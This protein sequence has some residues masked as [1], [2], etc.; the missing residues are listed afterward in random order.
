MILQNQ[1]HIFQISLRIELDPSQYEI[2]FII[3]ITISPDSLVEM[4]G[5]KPLF[6]N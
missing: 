5:Y 2:K 1:F 6:P 4:L 3:F